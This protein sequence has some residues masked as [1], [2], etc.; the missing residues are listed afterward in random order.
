MHY[1]T[2]IDNKK[3][4]FIDVEHRPGGVSCVGTG[5][6]CVGVDA[7]VARGYLNGGE[8]RCSKRLQSTL[9]A[10][11]HWLI[12]SFFYLKAAVAQWL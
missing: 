7:S 1:D 5:R 6:T 8:L 9:P 11:E 12:W 10:K 3:K 2:T 4:E